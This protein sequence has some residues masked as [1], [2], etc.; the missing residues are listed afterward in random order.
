MGF[1]MINNESTLNKH[2]TS[3]LLPDYRHI[4]LGEKFTS[5]LNEFKQD[6]AATIFLTPAKKC[7]CQAQLL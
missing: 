2:K 6:R 3:V 1:L 7:N 5:H 4:S